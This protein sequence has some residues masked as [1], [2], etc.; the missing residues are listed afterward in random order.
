MSVGTIRLDFQR[1]RGHKLRGGALLLAAG[2]AIGMALVFSY[3]HTANEIAGI[4]LQLS[5][6]QPGSSNI[7][8]ESDSSASI[9][10]ASAT[11]ENLATPWGRLLDDLEAATGDSAGSVALLEIEPDREHHKIRVL[12]EARSLV[13]A[14][15]YLERLQRAGT[16][17]NPLLESH[18]LQKEDPERPVRVKIMADWRVT[19]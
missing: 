10:M 16:L 1:R 5:A 11:V 7:A 4:E 3:R 17:V 9:A 19:S 14:L 12:A 15:G 2:L 13:A 6:L 18:E 8:G